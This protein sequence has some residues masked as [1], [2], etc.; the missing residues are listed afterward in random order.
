MQIPLGNFGNAIPDAAPR[1]NIPAGAFNS[2]EGLQKA[3]GMAMNVADQM[4]EDQKALNRVK[5]ANAL[6]DYQLSAKAA[7]L[8]LAGMLKDGSVS[9]ADAPAKYKELVDAIQ[10]PDPTSFG[11]PIIAEHLKGAIPQTFAE[12]MNSIQPMI[13]GALTMEQ[14]SAVDLGMDK[15]GKLAGMPGADVT[16]ELASLNAYDAEGVKSYGKEWAK[17]KQ[18][19]T[20]KTWTNAVA[21]NIERNSHSVTALQAI[22]AD[23]KDPKGTYSDKLDTNVRT[24]LLYKVEEQIHGTIIDANQARVMAEHEKR[25]QQD[26]IMQDYLTRTTKGKLTV[27][28]VLKN[29]TLDFEQKLHMKNIIESSVKGMDR[30]DPGTFMDI[31]NRIHAAPGT[32]NAITAPDQIYPYVG[33]G[34]SITDMSRLRAEVEGKNQPEGEMIKGFKKMAQDRIDLTTIMGKDPKGAENFYKWNTYFDQ[35]FAEQRKAGKSVHDLLDPTSKDYLGKTINGFAS[36]GADVIKNQVEQ[37]SGQI[38]R[39]AAQDNPRARK[40]VPP[41]NAKGWKLQTDAKGNK[42]YVSPDGKQYEEVK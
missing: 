6:Q 9:S 21:A 29:P 24:Q 33:K 39:E 4:Q 7:G 32:A 35:Q 20:D 14:K 42:A 18:E 19:F 23:L 3:G 5:A 25:Q 1:V 30:T 36:S 2:G 38:L 41:K 31:F 15:I 8:T 17:L 22:Q 12:G 34:L 16:K 13:S 26:Q 27:T 10:K 37:L 28:E 11:D 40:D